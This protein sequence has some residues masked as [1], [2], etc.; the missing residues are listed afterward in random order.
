MHRFI[1]AMLLTLLILVFILASVLAA[2]LGFA[3]IGWVV[4]R[5]FPM[6]LLQSTALAVVVGAGLA[7]IAYHFFSMLILRE[8]WE[9][10]EEEEEDFEPPVVPWRRHRPTPAEPEAVTQRARKPKKQER[11]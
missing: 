5:V 6:G 8:E 4:N 7:Y 2:T 9:E 10:W 11:K 1:G 3:S